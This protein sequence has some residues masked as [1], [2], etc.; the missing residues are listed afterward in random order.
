VEGPAVEGALVGVARA[1]TDVGRGLRAAQTG[2]VRTY[3]FAMVAGAA[4]VGVV[5]VLALR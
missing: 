3:A 1:L 5:F 4:I 2:L